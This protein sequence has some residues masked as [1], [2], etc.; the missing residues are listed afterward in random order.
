MKK[1]YV[2]EY[3]L[4]DEGDT[5]MVDTLKSLKAFKEVI[6]SLNGYIVRTRKVIIEK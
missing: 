2:I 4:N 3:V 5:T 1:K 6:E